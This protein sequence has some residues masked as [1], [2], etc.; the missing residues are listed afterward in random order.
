MKIDINNG[1][2]VVK[3]NNSKFNT[4]QISQL[5][6]FGFTKVADGTY[7]SYQDETS[8][9]FYKVFNYFSETGT[10]IELSENCQEKLKQTNHE[11]ELFNNLLES[12]KKYKNGLYDQQKNAEFITFV[13][14]NIQR[15]LK[16]HQKKAAYHHYLLKNAA[17]FSVPGSGKTTVVLTVYEKLRQDGIVDTLFVVGPPAC[18][19]PW[20][21]EF[22]ETLGRKADCRM[23]AGGNNYNRKLEYYNNGLQKGELYLSTFQSLTNDLSDAKIFFSNN[24]IF[25]II[26]EAHYIKQIGGEWARTVLNLAPYAKNRIILTG[27][28]LPRSYTDIF[29]Y[30]DFLFPNTPPLD[31]LLKSKI[32]VL[33]KEKSDEEVKKIY[34]SK[35]DPLTFRVRKKDLGLMPAIFHNPVFVEMNKYE[36]KLYEAII[37][38]IRNYSVDDYLQNIELVT[39]IMRGRI[40]RLRQI[41]SYSKLLATAIDNYD[42]NLLLGE[43]DLASIILNYD[44]IEKPGKIRKLLELID[45][46][47][48]RKQKVVIWS[49]FR[50]TLR[51][52]KREIVNRNYNCEMIFGETPTQTTSISDEKT[53]EQIRDEFVSPDSGMDVLIANPAACAESISLHK[54]CFNSIY[55]DLSYNCAQYLQSLDRIHR[56]GGSEIN[57][58][59]YF[60]LQYQNTID[61]DILQNLRIKSQKMYNLIEEDFNIYTLDMFEEDEDLSAY[62]RLFGE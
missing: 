52:I 12:A 9:I 45:E 4:I 36:K 28:P 6:Y 16:D 25:F 2:I 34:T 33:E 15:K 22:L 51:L 29:N 10:S 61:E 55:Y 59:N 31:D 24:N 7:I 8:E 20:K 37:K 17:N 54:T 30:F 38:K 60:F 62:K 43:N 11:K 13:E 53:R 48:K 23:L 46:L 3:E 58:A 19:G 49:N 32:E 40:I 14:R 35:I 41:V 27:T 56:V 21:S 47:Q 1:K 5:R 18:F 44:Q 26:D 50:E 42:E 39:R 57:Q